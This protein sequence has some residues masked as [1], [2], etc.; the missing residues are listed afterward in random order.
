MKILWSS[1]AAV[2]AFGMPVI[3]DNRKLGIGYYIARD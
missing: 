3:S 1:L 2:V